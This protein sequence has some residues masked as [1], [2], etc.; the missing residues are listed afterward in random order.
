MQN[1]SIYRSKYEYWKIFIYR[2]ILNLH[3]S[4]NI[5]ILIL[6]DIWLHISCVTDA[7]YTGTVR[8]HI[9]WLICDCS[10]GFRITKFQTITD[11]EQAPS[12]GR[13]LSVGDVLASFVNAPR[14]FSISISW[15]QILR[16]ISVRK[17][18]ISNRQ[19]FL[20][21]WKFHKQ[22]CC[23][24]A[25]VQ[26]YNKSLIKHGNLILNYRLMTVPDQVIF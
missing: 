25:I 6:T 18:S 11:F 5:R 24:Q 15:F 3:I 26:Q 8:R 13:F 22:F 23:L 4:V 19:Q 16:K 14:Q 12:R 20:R 1:S 7:R 21:K 10:L 17:I 9:I 2:S